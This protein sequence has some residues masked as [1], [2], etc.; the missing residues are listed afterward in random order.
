MFAQAQA[1]GLADQ[2]SSLAAHQ[3]HLEAQ[4]NEAQAAISA[5]KHSRARV[6]ALKPA[7][8]SLGARARQAALA[9]E[10][11]CTRLA[12][13]DAEIARWVGKGLHK[14][15]YNYGSFVLNS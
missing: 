11:H 8:A 1:A 15:G 6:A 10:S 5:A 9:A 13:L 7:V 4:L 3:R 12:T 14:Q 2:I